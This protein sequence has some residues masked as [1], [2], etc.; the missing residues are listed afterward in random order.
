MP[1]PATG[2]FRYDILQRLVRLSEPE[3]VCWSRSGEHATFQQCADGTREAGTQ[4]LGAVTASAP[5]PGSVRHLSLYG[6]DPLRLIRTV[7]SASPYRLGHDLLRRGDF[8][9]VGLFDTHDRTWVDDER[10]SIRFEESMLMDIVVPG[11]ETVITGMKMFTRVFS[12]S[13]PASVSGRIRSSG[14]TTIRFSCR[15]CPVGNP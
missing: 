15:L 5:V 2:S 3:N 14:C 4:E 10:V 6:A 7:N 1:T 13:N 9:Y 12:R 8:E 11:G